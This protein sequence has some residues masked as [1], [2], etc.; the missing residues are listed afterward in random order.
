MWGTMWMKKILKWREKRVGPNLLGPNLQTTLSSRTISI[1]STIK[2]Q[3]MH[4]LPLVLCQLVADRMH[5]FQTLLRIQRRPSYHPRLCLHR[6][7]SILLKMCF[8][9]LAADVVTMSRLRAVD[10]IRERRHGHGHGHCSCG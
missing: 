2:L 10:V 8:I 3:P 6:F 5:P 1:H 9:F 4:Q 7:V